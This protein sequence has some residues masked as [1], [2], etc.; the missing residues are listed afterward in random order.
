MERWTGLGSLSGR[1]NRIAATDFFAEHGSG[2]FDRETCLSSHVACYCRQLA[3]TSVVIILLQVQSP[4][5][6]PLLASA[7]PNHINIP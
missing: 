5:P 6:R 2:G 7:Y 4:R 3:Q 1:E